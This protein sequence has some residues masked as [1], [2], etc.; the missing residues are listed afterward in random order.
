L[1]AAW[2]S[3]HATVRVDAAFD[4]FTSRVFA[5]QIFAA[6]PLSSAWAGNRQFAD[7]AVRVRSADDDLAQKFWCKTTLIPHERARYACPLRYPQQT[8]A[9]CPINDEHW[10]KQGCVTTIAASIGARLRYQIDRSTE[11]YKTILKQRTA[12][13]RINSQA[14]DLGIERP[15]LRNAASIANHNTLTYVLI[16]LHALQRIRQRKAERT[17]AVT[18]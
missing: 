10:A 11:L 15:K 7:T 5:P 3:N 2:I 13:E 6:V 9:T 8:A 1:N 4:A 17:Q 18:T 14:V 16:N 12:T